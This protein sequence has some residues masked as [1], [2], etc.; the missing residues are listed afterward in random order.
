MSK[1][2]IEFSKT[3]TICYKSHLDLM[4][5]FKRVFKRTGIALAYSQGFNPHPK[6]GFAQPLS[7]GYWGME[8]YIEF[9]TAEEWQ[10]DQLLQ[11]LAGGLPEG[12]VLKRILE[13]EHLTKTLAAHTEAA[14]YLIE[15]PIAG[16]TGEAPV[17]PEDGAAP[18]DLS[19]PRAIWHVYMDQNEILAWKRQKKKKEPKQIDIKPMIREITFT[20]VQGED[21]LYVDALLDGG[22]HSNLSPEL[23]ITT[24]M[25]RLGIRTDRSEISVVRKRLLFDKPLDELLKG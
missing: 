11:R 20:P 9:E 25:E 21:I 13:A 10:P 22:S 7:L 24:A 2:I 15:I 23:V 5:I 16:S 18:V 14:Q 19:D 17:D 6:M 3:G 4:R 12:I 1:Y 8:E